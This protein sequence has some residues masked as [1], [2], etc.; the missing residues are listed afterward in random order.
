MPEKK[1]RT[2]RRIA[3]ERNSML[4]R[5]ESFPREELGPRVDLPGHLRRA[6]WDRRVW[7]RAAA[8][9]KISLRMLSLRWALR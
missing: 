8:P 7:T 2:I 3:P 6:L 1:L 9:W 4:G 5:V